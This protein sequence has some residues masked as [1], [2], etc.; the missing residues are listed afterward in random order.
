M[1]LS[2]LSCAAT[3]VQKTI[4]SSTKIMCIHS[5]KLQHPNIVQLV[6]IYY[7]SPTDELPWLVMELMPME[8]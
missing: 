7:P 8:A 1:L 2:I 6:G 3:E 5:G 4:N